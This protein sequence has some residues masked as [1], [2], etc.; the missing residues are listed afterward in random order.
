MRKAIKKVVALAA[1]ATLVGAT[2]GAA[3]AADL[4]DYPAPFIQDGEFNGIL[5]VG[6]NAAM[7][8]VIG[9]TDIATSLQFSAKTTKVVSGG[10]GAVSVEGDAWA[11][12]TSAK[13]LE[14]KEGFQDILSKLTSSELDALGDGS[15]TTDK[16]T[17]DYEQ[18]I[19][20]G[21][22][23]VE[24]EKSSG[25]QT[26][27]AVADYVKI[28]NG[29]PIFNYSL[30]FKTPL[31]SDVEDSAGDADTTGT[32]LGDYED[33]TLSIL[34]QTF[35]ILQAR[36]TSS[37]KHESVKLTLLGGKISDTIEEGE[38]KTYTLDGKDYEIEN[39]IVTDSGTIYTQFKVNG[40]VTEKMREGS[41]DTLQDGT[42]LGVS[43]ILPN[44]AGDVT[45][46]LVTFSFGAN[47]L[48]IEDTDI[49]QATDT[50][51]KKL[52]VNDDSITEVPVI[53]EGTDDNSTFKI[54]KIKMD[55]RAGHDYWIPA[56][57]TLSQVMAEEGDSDIVP[58]MLELDLKYEGMTEEDENEIN[59]IPSGDEEYVI[60]FK[61]NDGDEITLPLAYDNASDAAN[62]IWGD[63][64]YRL[65]VSAEL[66]LSVDEYVIVTDSTTSVE[67]N[68]NV[69]KYENTDYES[70]TNQA[71]V[72]LKS[73]G[74]DNS[75]YK[76]VLKADTGS[77]NGLYGTFNMDG[78]E[79]SVTNVT[80]GSS[81]TMRIQID[82][83]SNTPS[84]TVLVTENGAK[85]TLHNN[86]TAANVGAVE[87]ELVENNNQVETDRTVKQVIY[88]VSGTSNDQQVDL[89]R[90]TQ[91]VAV[92]STADDTNVK[93]GMNA[94]GLSLT[95]T[96]VSSGPDTVEIMMPANQK[97]AQVFVTSGATTTSGATSGGVVSTEV[98]RIDVGAT[99]MASKVLSSVG[100]Q[101]LI[102]VGG[103]CANAVAASVMGNPE[104]CADGFTPGKAMIKLFDTGADTVA[105]LVAGYSGEDTTAAA[106]VVARFEQ[107]ADVFS[108][109]AVEVSETTATEPTVGPM[110][111]AVV[112]EAPAAEE[113]DMMEETA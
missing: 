79:Y 104:N 83:V 106:Q 49:V 51:S 103:P 21:N 31:E 81:N 80:D 46:D 78:Y 37:T 57:A 12:E 82:G 71:T 9:V 7:A 86:G 33:K 70:D 6:D 5:V 91:S 13:K 19:I 108:G 1:G 112:E 45:A 43:T 56:G 84:N 110:M 66:N 102:V 28:A 60:E 47:K 50:S 27:K 8:D 107:Y 76:A 4:A 40:E 23:T 105:L 77:G 32:Y 2:F 20:L 65:V 113:D 3:F 97:L 94:Y 96:R 111:E 55:I 39:I 16:G 75:E 10:T 34:G 95:D 85:I 44:E 30:E 18:F 88:N 35:N 62:V 61:N 22:N 38:T 68:T 29:K 59:L 15:V 52:R 89:S 53:I 98:V 54:E 74:D 73:I 41:T 63:D 90:N 92:E 58:A 67:G 11:V 72:E 69:L 99:Q 24:F 101:N 64:S 36:R 87:V 42:V 100:A 109:E 48:E 93:V 14:L 25:E 26:D 17:S